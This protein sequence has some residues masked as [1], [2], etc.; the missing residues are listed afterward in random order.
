[1]LAHAEAVSM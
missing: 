1:L